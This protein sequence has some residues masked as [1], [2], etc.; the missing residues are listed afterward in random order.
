M[1]LVFSGVV[2]G[3][4]E[5]LEMVT[6][7]VM[8]Y[9]G[10]RNI[11]GEAVNVSI[12]GVHYDPVSDSAVCDVTLT[13]REFVPSDWQAQMTGNQKGTVTTRF[14]QYVPLS[15]EVDITEYLGI[16]VRRGPSPIICPLPPG[17]ED[18]CST[19][20]DT[21]TP[22]DTP[23]DTP[24][25]H[26]I[27]NMTI[28]SNPVVMGQDFTIYLNG[29]FTGNTYSGY[30]IKG[31]AED[32][33]Y[34]PVPF[35]E[36]PVTTPEI[37]SGTAIGCLDCYYFYA[38]N[39][40][41]R[42][43]TFYDQVTIVAK[44]SEDRVLTNSYRSI[45]DAYAL[46][47]DQEVTISV[48]VVSATITPTMDQATPT[49]T[50]TITPTNTQVV[51]ENSGF[52]AVYDAWTG[53][54]Q[55]V[56]STV[57]TS[58]T[59]VS[60]TTQVDIAGQ[61]VFAMSFVHGTFANSYPGGGGNIQ[62]S[63]NIGDDLPTETD[64]KKSYISG[65]SD[66]FSFINMGIFSASSPGD[67]TF[68]QW[69]KTDSNATRNVTFTAIDAAMFAWPLTTEDNINTVSAYYTDSAYKLQ[70]S[71]STWQ[72]ITG[73]TINLPVA[74]KIAAFFTCYPSGGA[75][76]RQVSYEILI[77]G[78]NYGVTTTVTAGSGGSTK[79]QASLQALSPQLSLGDHV[80]EIRAYS[81]SDTTTYYI[82]NDYSQLVILGLSSNTGSGYQVSANSYKNDDPY[83]FSSAGPEYGHTVPG[84]S[85]VLHKYLNSKYLVIGNVL[86]PG[87]TT[88]ATTD[89]IG[90]A[91]DVWRHDA[92]NSFIFSMSSD[93]L[94]P[95]N[96]EAYINVTSTTGGT[97]QA[98]NILF[99]EMGMFHNQ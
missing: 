65:A 54:A 12:S 57:F 62:H 13:S 98:P 3:R 2:E 21:A 86:A 71:A 26:W 83:T 10:E 68:R 84:A 41:I 94:I 73:T 9:Y 1:P 99:F 36:T 75:S 59:N 24:T 66:D 63:L 78:Y 51:L 76:S 80:V 81:P 61:T 8:S 33:T 44:I 6:Y 46:L 19:P 35:F 82:F 48:A 58:L 74:G 22:T 91:S 47:G 92:A 49:V 11:K 50:A 28:S 55:D 89:D 96:Y 67:V 97:I 29:E 31:F 56:T 37:F 60:V 53:L 43:G 52:N 17:I 32:V 30:R 7:G 79:H 45:P 16:G 87:V 77:G 72:H 42:N 27:P 18:P 4:I 85:V 25:P 39:S 70:E 40:V 88:C 95:G 69:V 14:A 5:N 90:F 34:T 20:E 23:T 93:N 15:F 38:A 64:G